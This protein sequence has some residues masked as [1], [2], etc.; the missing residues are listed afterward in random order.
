MPP[1]CSSRKL[2]RWQ[3]CCYSLRQPGDTQLLRRACSVANHFILSCQ[4]ASSIQHHNKMLCSLSL[5]SSPRFERDAEVVHALNLSARFA[6]AL[7]TRLEQAFIGGLV[8][9]TPYLFRSETRQRA[10]SEATLLRSWLVR[11]ALLTA[12]HLLL[13]L[14]SDSTAN[15]GRSFRGRGTPALQ[16]KYP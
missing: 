10:L 15:C 14:C 6:P 8:L 5:A 2:K 4:I 9:E 7:T 12:T 1:L 11:S 16:H 3:S 13:V